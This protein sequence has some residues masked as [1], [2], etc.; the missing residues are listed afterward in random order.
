MPLILG[1]DPGNRG[2]A[3]LVDP[4]A[5]T[6]LGWCWW[7]VQRKRP[8]CQT[9]A[10]GPR[11]VD[12]LA[13]VS[14]MLAFDLDAAVVAIEALAVRKKQTKNP[15]DVVACSFGA[16]V[17]WG[18]YS[19]SRPHRPLHRVE[20]KDWASLCGNLGKTQSERAWRLAIGRLDW[21]VLPPTEAPRE[22]LGA[23]GEAA[24]IAL[25]AGGV[26]V[27]LVPA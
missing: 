8:I 23:I 14:A 5:R 9:H 7:D 27:S 10:D 17:L 16:G 26:R 22:A 6:V 20:P 21:R 25:W 19:A 13:D 3:C 15:A 12:D 4:E 2:G 18:G 24:M 11:P 1:I